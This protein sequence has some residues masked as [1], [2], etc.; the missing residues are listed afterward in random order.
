[1]AAQIRFL[2]VAFR[3]KFVSFG[4][5]LPVDMLG[6]FAVVM[7]LMLREFGG[8]TVKGTLMNPTDKSFYDLVGQQ[9]EVLKE[10]CLI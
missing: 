8:K 10:G 6:T 7:D 4:K 2:F 9:F 1:M 3:V 5:K